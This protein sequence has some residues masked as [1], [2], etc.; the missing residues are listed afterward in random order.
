MV[1]AR[2]ANRCG[3]AGS[4]MQTRIEIAPGYKTHVFVMYAALANLIS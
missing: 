3:R 1:C 2:Q 4:M